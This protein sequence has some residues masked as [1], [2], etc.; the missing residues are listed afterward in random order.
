M[1]FYT[2]TSGYGYKPWKGKFYPKD[3]PDNK[4]LSYYS[5]NFPA[6]EINNTFYSMP[7]KS[8]L[9]S[10]IKEVSKDFKFILKAPGE[11]THKKRLKN[12]EEELKYFLE[13]SASLKKNLSGFLFQ[14]PPNFKKNIETLENFINLIPKKTKVTFEF[15]NDSWFDDE[16]YDCLRKRDFALCTADTDEK[17]AGIINT[18]S[19][20]YLRLRKESYDNKELKEWYKK[21]KSCDWKDVY[22]FFKHED[23]A[24]GP[25]FAKQFIEIAGDT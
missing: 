10:W 4:M 13:T 24:N 7:K 18:A 19:W 16:T 22:I 1:N 11:I 3:L 12:C 9:E 2:G 14:L 21:I 5:G 20:G 6:V 25:R 15:R 17:P 8:I 23:K